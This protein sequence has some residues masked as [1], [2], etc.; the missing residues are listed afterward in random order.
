MFG[1][2]IVNYRSD[3]LTID[4]VQKELS[5][6]KL[7]HIIVVVNNSAIESSNNLLCDSLHATLVENFNVSVCQNESNV[8]VIS[9][10]EN[11]GFAKGNNLGVRFLQKHYPFCDYV[12]FSNNDIQIVDSDVCERLI[13]KITS[14]REIGLIGPKVIGL[15]GEFQSPEPYIPM[16]DYF[17]WMYLFTLFLSKK[18]KRKRFQLDYSKNAKEGYH[19]KVMGSFFIVRLSDYI[20]CGM[21]DEM[22]F[23]YAEEVI[24]SERLKSIGKKVYYYPR[25]SVVHAHGVTTKKLGKVGINKFLLDSMMYYYHNYM[26]E[27][28]WKCVLCR[29]FYLLVNRIK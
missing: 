23:L 21:M 28:R 6:I 24:L 17:C 19:Y 14:N 15:K 27:P 5:K 10:E 8:Y 2:I 13:K 16:A 1:I 18:K 7:P 29:W 4:Y 9:S 3:L 25:V 20:A 26:L 11:L 22:T 12:L